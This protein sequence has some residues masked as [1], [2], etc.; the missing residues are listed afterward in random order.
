M[1]FFK[2]IEKKF[3]ENYLAVRDNDSLWDLTAI[4]LTHLSKRDG[5]EF[6][7]SATPESVKKKLVTTYMR[8][9]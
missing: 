2:S 8:G 7:V 5:V 9:N 1:E 4:T 3:F 6:R